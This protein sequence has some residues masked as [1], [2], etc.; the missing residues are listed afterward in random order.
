MKSLEGAGLLDIAGHGFVEYR[1]GK[2]DTYL[3]IQNGANWSLSELESLINLIRSIAQRE[4]PPQE[5]E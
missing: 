3:F 4:Q 1:I 2:S 5:A